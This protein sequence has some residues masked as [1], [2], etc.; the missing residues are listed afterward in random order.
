M[1]RE[2][3]AGSTGEWTGGT[4]QVGRRC[5]SAPATGI[6]V[7]G[8]ALEGASAHDTDTRGQWSSDGQLL[9]LG[10]PICMVLQ[11]NV[12]RCL[13]RLWRDHEPPIRAV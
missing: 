6:V 9:F 3:I 12:T 13:R 4:M 8:V 11:L 7:S 10:N 2:V 1:P 5:Q